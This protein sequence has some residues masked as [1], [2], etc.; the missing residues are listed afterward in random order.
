M[1]IKTE[2]QL[3][4]QALQGKIRVP[5]YTFTVNVQDKCQ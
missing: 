3:G 5:Y 4:R 2:P 1:K